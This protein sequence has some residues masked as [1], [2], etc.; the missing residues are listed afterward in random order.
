MPKAAKKD[1]PEVYFTSIRTKVG[2]S[3][4]DKL[5]R[6]LDKAGFGKLGLERKYVAVLRAQCRGAAG[7]CHGGKVCPPRKADACERV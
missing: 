7:V 5:S 3:L 1:I 4:L 2:T 6:L